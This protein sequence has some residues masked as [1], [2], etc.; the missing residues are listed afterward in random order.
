MKTST[1]IALSSLFSVS[2]LANT[3]ATLDMHTLSAQAST[4]YPDIKWTTVD[5][6]ASEL[7]K[8]PIN[9]GLDIDDTMLFSS[10]VFY[11]GKQKYSPDSFDYLKNQDFWNEASTGLDRFSIPKKSAIELVSMHL[12]H[13]DTVYFITGRTAPEGQETVTETLRNIFPK[14]FGKQIKPVIFAGSLDKV[15]QLKM[16]KIAQYYGD[17]DE[18]ITSSREA[19]VKAIRFLR[20]AQTTYTPLPHAGKYGEEVLINSNY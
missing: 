17:S 20:G 2:V 16:A 14:E 4:Q 7:P 10:P 1:I 15:Q 18:D 6:I 5:K 12:K 19:G 9:V 8:H 3:P 13:G 11:Y